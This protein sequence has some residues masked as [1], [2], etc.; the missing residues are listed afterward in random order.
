MINGVAHLTSPLGSEGEFHKNVLEAIR[1][2]QEVGLE[3]EIHYQ[4]TANGYS[5]LIIG[6]TKS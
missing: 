5:A 4:H 1:K 2:H 3:V 6:R